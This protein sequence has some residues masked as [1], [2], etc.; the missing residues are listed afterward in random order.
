MTP[1]DGPAGSGGPGT[2]PPA[3]E[4]DTRRGRSRW[5]TRS[6]AVRLAAAVAP[7]AAVTF[8][9]AV[10]TGRMTAANLAILTSGLSACAC[11]LPLRRPRLV[12]RAAAAAAVSATCTV[13]MLTVRPALHVWGAG[14]ALALLVLLAEVVRRAPKSTGI[15]LGGLLAI[16]AVTTPPRDSRAGV[17]TAAVSALAVAVTAFS[18][19]LRTQDADRDRAVEQARTNERLELACELHDFVAHHV[20]GILI[21]AQT[22][23]AVPGDAAAQRP[24]L[25]S[26]ENAATESLVAMRR[27]VSVLREADTGTAPLAGLADIEALAAETRR[28][29]LPVTLS[30]EPALRTDLAPNLAACAHRIVREAL[31]NTRKHAPDATGVHPHQP[32]RPW[33]GRRGPR[34]A[35]G[36]RASAAADAPGAPE[37]VRADRPDRACHGPR[38]HPPVRSHS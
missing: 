6:A 8:E 21:Q 14:E 37:R 9:A 29:G 12:V 26:I 24:R 11:A 2:R 23:L 15:W 25:E 17:V 10:V 33:P 35:P 32:R 5:T 13:V 19:Y 3:P 30:I 27:V 38:R 34:P 36:R 20:T 4:R 31:T 18:I 16:V 28:S 1:E 22:A 7:A